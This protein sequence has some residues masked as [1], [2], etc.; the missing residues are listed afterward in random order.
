MSTHDDD[1]DN[2]NAI[3]WSKWLIMHQLKITFET[4]ITLPKRP[5]RLS[6]EILRT[7]IN[8]GYVVLPDWKPRLNDQ[9]PEEL[10]LIPEPPDPPEP[11]TEEATETTAGMAARLFALGLM[12]AT[13]EE[14]ERRASA[15]RYANAAFSLRRATSILEWI[16]AFVPRRIANEE[17][18]DALE[19]I[20]Q[21]AH[22]GR[23]FVWAK[24]V[25]TIFFVLLNVVRELAASMLGKKRGGG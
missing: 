17:I 25:T 7:Y 6:D 22:K 19:V 21:N 3:E 18:G 1:D 9:S 23:L 5:V 13:R 20:Y 15:E 2:E 8:Q 10:L 24:V 14:A 16:T 11:P 12:K 4:D